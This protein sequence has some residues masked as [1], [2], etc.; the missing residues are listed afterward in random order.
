MS[1]QPRYYYS[2][3]N[4]SAIDFARYHKIVIITD[5]N[6]DYLYREL[7]LQKIPRA[8]LVVFP[9][10]E[11]NKTRETKQYI[12]DQLMLLGCARDCL[13]IAFGGGVVTDITG[14]VAGTY[15]RG[16][17]VIYIPTTLMAMVD[18]AIGGKTGLN[19]KFGKNLIGMFNLPDAVVI[20]TYFLASLSEDDYI[21]AFSEVIK[22]ALIF[23]ADYLTFIENNIIGIKARDQAL[24]AS[25]VK[26]SIAIK[27]AIIKD[28][29]RD[30]GR[31]QILNFGHNIGHAI[32]TLSE[33]KISHGRAV[34]L[35]ILYESRLSVKYTKLSTVEFKRI[36]T[37][38]L[39]FGYE[40]DMPYSASEIYS[41][42][43]Y[44]KKNRGNEVNYIMLTKIGQAKLYF[45]DCDTL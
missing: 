14:F 41:A 16:V 27:L 34:A 28:D 25:I 36:E 15:Y 3:E 37:L 10:G 22:H 45:G 26:K 13:L 30:M 23:D 9:A 39:N 24:I 12:E 21:Y 17:S 40:P 6:V 5:T 19:T 33:Y 8:N 18:A 7:I 20:D 32:E 2:L 29:L 43:K 44:D 38:L 31:R 42:M 35:G 11:I 1:K 4:L